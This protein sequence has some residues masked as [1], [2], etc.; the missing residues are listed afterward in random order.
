MKL[1][2][3]KKLL[4]VIEFKKD[5]EDV[6]VGFFFSKEEDEYIGQVSE[7][8]DMGDVLI[9]I[10]SLIDSYDIDKQAMAQMLIRKAND[11]EARNKAPAYRESK[12]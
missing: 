2:E 6:F 8:A 7:S 11:E 4:R 1:E 5:K 9:V 12:N 10:N 3:A